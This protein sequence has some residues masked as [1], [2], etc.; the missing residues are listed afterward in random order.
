M[1]KINPADVNDYNPIPEIVD[2]STYR[3]LKYLGLLD[4]TGLR[5]YCIKR[6]YVEYRHDGLSMFDSLQK[7]SVEYGLSFDYLRKMIG[8]RRIYTRKEREIIL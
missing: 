2:S 8:V 5:N 7:L 6:L 3:R 1:E 4:T